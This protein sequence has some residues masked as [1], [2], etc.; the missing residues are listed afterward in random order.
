MRIWSL[1]I[2]FWSKS[3]ISVSWQGEYTTLVEKPR[4]DLYMEFYTYT[5]RS[6]V[7]EIGLLDSVATYIVRG[8]TKAISV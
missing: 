7:K 4:V 8:V 3:F 2:L 6:Q 5:L 1:I